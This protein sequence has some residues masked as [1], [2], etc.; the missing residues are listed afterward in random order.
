MEES[1]VMIK[2]LIGCPGNIKNDGSIMV[3]SRRSQ[4]VFFLMT[5]IYCPGKSPDLAP[6]GIHI[7]Q[8]RSKVR[9]FFSSALVKRIKL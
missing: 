7:Q 3:F 6:I 4:S 5:I 8:K 2:Y 9:R 1:R